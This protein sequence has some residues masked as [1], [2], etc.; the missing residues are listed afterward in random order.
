MAIIL[1]LLDWHQTLGLRFPSPTATQTICAKDSSICCT[2]FAVLCRTV[3]LVNILQDNSS[4]LKVSFLTCSSAAVCLLI[5][6]VC[7]I[8]TGSVSDETVA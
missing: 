1:P 3:K 8:L 4:Q 5:C 7:S 6:A 2:C